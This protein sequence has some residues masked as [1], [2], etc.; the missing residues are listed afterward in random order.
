MKLRRKLLVALV[1][2]PLLAEG[3]LRVFAN[4]TDRARGMRWD[5][6]PAPPTAAQA[7]E[8]HLALYRAA[9]FIAAP[10]ERDPS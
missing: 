6:L 8:R 1:L 7:A 4:A 9:G 5:A 2:L 10:V 3:A